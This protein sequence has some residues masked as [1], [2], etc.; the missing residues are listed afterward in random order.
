MNLSEWAR[1][2]KISPRT[3]YRRFKAGTL[4]VP[5]KKGNNG[6][7]VVE[8]PESSCKGSCLADIHT[9]CL[10]DAVLA[11]LARRGSGL[12]SGRVVRHHG[13]TP[14]GSVAQLET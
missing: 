13:E 9:L 8:A 14:V 6:R 12:D 7:I 1:R 4:G 11:E 10:V 3:A 2:Q 5:A